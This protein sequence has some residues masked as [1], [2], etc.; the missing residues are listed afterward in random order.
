MTCIFVIFPV[1]FYHSTKPC[2]YSIPFLFRILFPLKIKINSHIHNFNAHFHKSCKPKDCW[3][4]HT[5]IINWPVFLAME[6]DNASKTFNSTLKYL[7]N[8]N[9]ITDWNVKSLNVNLSDKYKSFSVAPFSFLK[10]QSTIRMATNSMLSSVCRKYIFY[11][12]LSI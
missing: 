10:P 6:F 8:N 7:D 9:N 3:A 1:S 4:Y 2:L 5:G 11:S 12:F